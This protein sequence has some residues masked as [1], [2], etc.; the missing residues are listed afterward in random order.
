MQERFSK[1]EK[2]FAEILMAA[3]CF[4]HFQ[5]C[6]CSGLRDYQR[7][8]SNAI[9]VQTVVNVAVVIKTQCLFGSGILRSK[10]IVFKRSLP[11]RIIKIPLC[12]QQHVHRSQMRRFLLF[13]QPLGAQY[14]GLSPETLT[15]CN[16]NS[17]W[18]KSISGDVY[19]LLTLL[20]PSNIPRDAECTFSWPICSWQTKSKFPWVQQSI[21]NIL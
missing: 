2:Q 4:E 1:S 19:R 20:F 15:M 12:Q 3:G 7:R 6:V 8:H 18:K 16:K 21:F 17:L 14:A 9:E 11:E 5:V 13:P 10:N